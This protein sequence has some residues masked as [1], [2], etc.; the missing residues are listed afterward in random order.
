VGTAATLAAVLLGACGN[1]GATGGPPTRTSTPTLV[2]SE[3]G[4]D[5]PTAKPSVAPEPSSK[6]ATAAD[7][8]AARRV[9][10]TW[11]GAV[12]SGDFDAAA[13]ASRD[14]ANAWT[15][16]TRIVAES[17]EAR[18]DAHKF[19]GTMR[20]ESVVASDSGAVLLDSVLELREVAAA[21]ERTVQITRPL[22]H[23]VSGVWFVTS[24]SAGGRQIRW[25]AIGVQKEVRGVRLEVLSV[26]D[27]L[28]GTWLVTRTT[29]A[30]G[31]RSF[32]AGESELVASAGATKKLVG[33]FFSADARPVGVWRFPE[34][35]E[36]RG[37]RLTLD[38]DGESLL[39]AFGS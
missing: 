6:T 31:S 8:A 34:V 39:F 18:G 27:V 32:T 25:T 7:V 12:L 14:G 10:R 23:K 11:S 15:V 29:V 1:S 24:F 37:I 20:G 33:A 13:A 17:D 21:G 35:D 36:I 2:A 5:V 3:S 9:W 26:L 38:E 16:V 28:G 30:Q 4:V 19:G 22:L